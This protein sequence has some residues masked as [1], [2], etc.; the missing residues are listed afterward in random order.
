MYDTK[1]NSSFLT[2]LSILTKII[3]EF[4][5]FKNLSTIEKL[6]NSVIINISETLIERLEELILKINHFDLKVVLNGL[7]LPINLFKIY[8][9]YRDPENPN[10]LYENIFHRYIN[11]LFEK[12]EDI[13]DH[14]EFSYILKSILDFKGIVL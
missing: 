1:N 6:I 12:I 8:T 5:A 11:F 10:K 14:E 4:K 13:Y 9:F 7:Q 2:I 3:W